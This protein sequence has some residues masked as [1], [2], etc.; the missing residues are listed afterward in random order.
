MSALSVYKRGMVILV[1]VLFCLALA[2]ASLYDTCY[3]GEQMEKYLVHGTEFKLD[4]RVDTVHLSIVL[5]K[6]QSMRGSRLEEAKEAS[7]WLVDALKKSDQMQLVAFDETAQLMQSLTSDKVRLKAAIESIIV[8]DRTRYNPALDLAWKGYKGDEKGVSKVMVFLSDGNPDDKNMPDS[9]LSQTKDMIADGICIFTINYGSTDTDSAQVLLRTMARMSEQ[10]LGCGKYFIAGKNSMDL[11]DVFGKIY[12]EVIADDTI[13]IETENEYRQGALIIDAML[14]SSFNNNRIPG[15]ITYAACMGEPEVTARVK[16]GDKVIKELDLKYDER[17][18]RY[19]GYMYSVP[20]GQYILETFAQIRCYDDSCLY[21]GLTEKI[22]DINGD[23]VCTNSWEQ[24]E[25]YI[26]GS[27]EDTIQVNIFDDHFEP[28]FLAI[29]RGQSIIWTNKGQNINNVLSGRGVWDGLFDSG[30][31]LPGETFRYTFPSE[32][33]VGFFS[34]YSNKFGARGN[35]TGHRVISTVNDVEMTLIL[36]SSGSMKGL[37]PEEAKVAAGNLASILR[38]NDKGAVIAFDDDATLI[39]QFS[40][41]P[42]KIMRSIDKLVAGESTLYLPALQLANLN[43]K[44]SYSNRDARKL[45]IFLSD[46]RPQDIGMTNSILD[47][48]KEMVMDNIC[49]YTIGYG[50]ELYYDREASGLLN[51][52]AEFSRTSIECG[53]YFFSFEKSD[54]LTKIFGEIYIGIT[55]GEELVLNVTNAQPFYE[56]GEEHNIT[57]TISSKYNSIAIPSA[58]GDMCVYPAEAKLEVRDKDNNIISIHEFLYDYIDGIYKVSF[59]PQSGEYIFSIIAG[60]YSR[61]DASQFRGVYEWHGEVQS[62]G[63]L[64]VQTKLFNNVV[65]LIFV[66]CI[67]F[68]IIFVNIQNIRENKKRKQKKF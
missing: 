67:L 8:G 23:E 40:S 41:D 37:K 6:S 60:V 65:F 55:K 34:N 14:T 46:G 9:I 10:A 18:K 26:V 3:N 38:T 24:V 49:L 42:E 7:I 63:A 36:D 53:K 21:G 54:I 58:S 30:P 13:N 56:E 28:S 35:V 25:T 47:S 43:Y 16:I 22:I 20:N 27:Y 50:A 31:L 62:K 33:E 51:E 5:D 59:V 61:E 45:I 57:M 39:Q 12:S 1:L 64:F 29:K 66:L 15:F 32:K 52:M 17:L 4:D 19:R 48:V 44:S 11:N 2:Q 68:I